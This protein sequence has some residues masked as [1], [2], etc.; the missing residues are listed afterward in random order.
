MK[1]FQ[2]KPAFGLPCPSA[3]CVKLETYLRMTET[4]YEVREGDPRQ[5]PKGKVPWIED[6]GR[7]IGDSSLIIDYLKDKHGDLL[8]GRLTPQQYAQGHAV[9]RMLEEHLYYVSSY[10]KWVEDSG[11]AIYAAELFAGMPA[12]QL[13]HVPP[14]VRQKVIDKLHAQGIARHSRDEVYS[15]GN[16][17]VSA[18][19]S[20][21]GNGPYLF[22]D[23]P[24]SFDACA[25]GVIGNIKD[26][27]F[28]NPVRDRIRA[29]AN[30]T[31]YIEQIRE[32][33]FGN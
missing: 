7:V 5:A 33:W 3:F 1:L 17:D 15:M 24:T 23:E 30:L 28:D 32:K 16:K 13:E 8:D 21:L 14:M 31:R 26:G 4:P 29:S 6:D 25:F 12:E 19:E 10:S 18:F 9:Q 2:P 22:G 20:M 11:F 27:P